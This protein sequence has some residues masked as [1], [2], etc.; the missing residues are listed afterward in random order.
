MIIQIELYVVGV[1]AL[2]ASLYCFAYATHKYVVLMGLPLLIA[3]LICLF[4][5][6]HI[7]ILT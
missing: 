5:A 7:R 6:D 4:V 3:A 1:L 2:M